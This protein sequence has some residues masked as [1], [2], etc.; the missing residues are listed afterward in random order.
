VLALDGWRLRRLEDADRLL[1]A[2]QASTLLVARDQRVL[3]LPLT[4]GHA[5]APVVTLAA[6]TQPSP[7]AM[8]LRQGWL[9]G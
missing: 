8:A 5:G 9:G 2:D 3:T 1:K 7:G 4:G 6:A